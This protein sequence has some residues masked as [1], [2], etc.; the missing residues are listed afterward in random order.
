MQSQLWNR[1]RCR[2]RSVI[3]T[4]IGRFLFTKIMEVNALEVKPYRVC[5][6]EDS[7]KVYTG[8]GIGYVTVGSISERDNPVIME[9]REDKYSEIWGR[10]TSGAGWIRLKFTKKINQD[11]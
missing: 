9:E 11:E 6:L 10:L 1:E 4:I 2:V 7:L 8:A 3:E 5:L